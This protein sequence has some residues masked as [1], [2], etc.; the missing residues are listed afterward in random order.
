MTED[1]A[2]WRNF[3]NKVTNLVFHELVGNSWIVERLMAS[4]EGLISG[5][6]VGYFTVWKVGHINIGPTYGR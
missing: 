6:L 5:E 3:L 2:E 1:R 4:Q